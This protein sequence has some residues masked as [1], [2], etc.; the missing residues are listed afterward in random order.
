MTSGQTAQAYLYYFSPRLLWLRLFPIQMCSWTFTSR[1]PRRAQHGWLL[2]APSLTARCVT[3]CLKCGHLQLVEKPPQPTHPIERGPWLVSCSSD[4]SIPHDACDSAPPITA[5][6]S[7]CFREHYN[8]TGQ[9]GCLYMNS[10]STD[11]WIVQVLMWNSVSFLWDHVKFREGGKRECVG[12]CGNTQVTQSRGRAL[13]GQ[14]CC[15]LFL[16]YILTYSLTQYS[17]LQTQSFDSTNSPEI[18]KRVYSSQ[19]NVGNLSDS[20]TTSMWNHCIHSLCLAVVMR[21][22]WMLM[23]IG[24][25]QPC[26]MIESSLFG[27]GGI[28]RRY[29]KFQM[30][31]MQ[32]WM[33]HVLR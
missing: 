31:K 6:M 10:S 14:C 3:P 5:L 33:F 7:S 11:W 13:L 25:R 22:A 19:Q 27:G 2:L 26:H 16:I 4:S 18:Q 24:P 9:H 28:R 21:A 12:C 17:L 20:I 15:N 29:L 32:L 1:K 23:S 30:K 8:G